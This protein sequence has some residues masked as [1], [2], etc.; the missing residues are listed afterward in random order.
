MKRR[1][2]LKGAFGA[3]GSLFCGELFAAPPEWKHEGT[4]NG[5][6]TSLGI[7][8]EELPRNKMVTF[9]VRPTS[10]LGTKGKPITGEFKEQ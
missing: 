8:K 2:F 1:D 10:S 6:V 5:G 4:P 7:P 9:T 3:I